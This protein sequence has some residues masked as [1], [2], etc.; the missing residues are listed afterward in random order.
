MTSKNYW[1]HSKSPWWKYL[2][3]N[4]RCRIQISDYKYNQITQREIWQLKNF[5]LKKKQTLLS[6]YFN[7]SFPRFLCLVERSTT[8]LILNLSLS[9][10]TPALP[11]GVS[12]VFGP[13]SVQ[14]GFS[15]VFLGVH[16]LSLLEK[17]N[18]T[19]LMNSCCPCFLGYNSQSRY[20]Q[21]V[22]IRK[23]FQELKE[24]PAARAGEV[25]SEAL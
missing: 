16:S 23:H 17:K 2:R 24:C 14:V 6:Q 18:H 15:V 8:L 3:W 9:H 20:K 1:S 13:L 22:P 25:L 12:A 5:K 11:G 19:F 4:S 21:A 7:L 10:A